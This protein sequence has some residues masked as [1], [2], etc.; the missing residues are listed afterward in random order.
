MRAALIMTALLVACGGSDGNGDVPHEPIEF[1]PPIID[2]EAV[3]TARQTRETSQ[4]QVQA[5]YQCGWHA[6]WIE[7]LRMARKDGPSAFRSKAVGRAF[8]WGGILLLGGLG[9]TLLLAWLLP[10]LR[11]RKANKERQD[12][13]ADA[14]PT[15][16]SY[17]RGLGLR[18]IARIGR[19]LRVEQFDPLLASERQRMIETCRDAERQLNVAHGAVALL[20]ERGAP[21]ATTIT[22]WR[23]EVTSLRRRL[24]G[25]AP[26]GPE[27]APDRISP[28][29]AVILRAA[30]D[31]RIAIERASIAG[32][33]ESSWVA[34]EH[35]LSDRPETPRDRASTPHAALAPWVRTVGLAGLGATV[36]ALP[37][38]ACWMAAGAFPLFFA[39]LFGLGGLGAVTLARVHLHRAGRLPL[40]PGFADRVARWLTTVLALTL[41]ATIISSWMTADGGLDMGDPPHVAM[42]DP[43]LLEAPKLFGATTT[44]PQSIPQTMPQTLPSTP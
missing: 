44:K 5:G 36:L 7:T 42:P 3:A 20:G 33:T 11:R 6:G 35:E 17:F 25:P 12:K 27:L 13:P 18:F 4:A 41:L 10:R 8:G 16:G 15:W 26:L 21:I 29:I 37:M 32:V 34:I 9:G 43:K 31:L 39:L 30:R 28:R 2:F 23:S 24:E 40:L 19:A 22:T 14:V 38:L 1:K